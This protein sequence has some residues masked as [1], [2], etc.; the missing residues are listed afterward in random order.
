VPSFLLLIFFPSLL[1]L[2]IFIVSSLFSVLM[3]CSLMLF[4][5]DFR[6]LV[7]ASSVGNNGWF[8][9]SSYSLHV[10]LSFFVVYCFSLLFVLAYLPNRNFY[11]SFSNPKI[12]IGFLLSLVSLSGFPPFPLFFLKL[13][14]VY[15]MSAYVPFFFIFVFLVFSSFLLAG[16]FR[17]LFS[18]VLFSFSFFV[19]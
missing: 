17:F 2:S 8:F 19:C 15:Y 1:T 7:L 13:I 12:V 9:F 5:S 4:T 6:S 18:F 16:Y 11:V 10:F 3:S 14:T